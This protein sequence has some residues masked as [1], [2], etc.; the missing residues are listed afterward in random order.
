VPVSSLRFGG[1][2]VDGDVG[3]GAVPEV[4]DHWVLCGG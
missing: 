2:A 4:E 3:D 1:G